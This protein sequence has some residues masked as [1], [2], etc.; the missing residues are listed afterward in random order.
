[1]LRVGGRGD[2]FSRTT[3][4]FPRVLAVLQLNLSTQ[5]GENSQ[6]I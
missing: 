1:V 2:I 6:M 4:T 5:Q 3:Y